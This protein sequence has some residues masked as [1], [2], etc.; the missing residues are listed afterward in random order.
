MFYCWKN[1]EV[2]LD[3]ATMSKF[4]SQSACFA[5]RDD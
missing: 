4:T 2:F 3:N 1:P 5:N